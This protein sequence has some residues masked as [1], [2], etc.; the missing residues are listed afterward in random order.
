MSCE[1][2]LPLS[3]QVAVITGASKGIGRETALTL[4]RAGASVCLGA[5]SVDLL[6]EVVKEIEEKGGKALAVQTDVTK[7]N[8]V[9]VAL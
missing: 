7:R 1:S 5:R 2:A 9:I 4:A 8:E 3:G 6:Q